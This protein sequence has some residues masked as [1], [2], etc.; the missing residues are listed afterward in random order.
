V[1]RSAHHEKSPGNLLVGLDSI[2]GRHKF[3]RANSPAI[4][5]QNCS[6][7]EQCVACQGDA[8]IQAGAD[9]TAGGSLPQQH[10]GS[11]AAS[12]R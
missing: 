3:I 6:A 12:A 2:S 10:G 9:A 4:D 11:R 5:T 7:A 8:R 1:E